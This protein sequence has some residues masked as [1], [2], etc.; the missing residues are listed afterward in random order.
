GVEHSAG[1]LGHGLSVS[2]GMALA[3]KSDKKSWQVYCILGDGESMEGSV[4]E[5]MMSASHYKL[6]NLTAII[7]RNH[8]SQEGTTAETMQL[9]PLNEK[10]EA[11]GWH[12][13]DV[14]GH[15]I[16]ELLEAFSANTGDQPKLIIANTI[17]G[18]GI[19]SLEN[20]TK[21]HFAHLNKDQYQL[22]LKQ[23]TND[24]NT[25]WKPDAN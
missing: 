20:Q 7:D 4:W 13:L 3:A 5:A 23:I 24:R 22:A 14:N 11:F 21:S 16:Q 2:T 25:S 6:N 17:K 8:L 15:S 12:V 18:R 10:A 9:E 1:S 19:A